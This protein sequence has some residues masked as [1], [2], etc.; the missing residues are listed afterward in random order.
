MTD[1]LLLTSFDI[2]KPHHVSNASDD[3]LLEMLSRNLLNE[4]IHLL[5][6]LPVDFDLAPQRVIDKLNELSPQT[7]ICCGMAERRSR[8]MIELNGKQPGEV[9]RTSVDVKSLIQQLENTEISQDAGKF[10]CN[11]LYHSLL[12]Y[13]QVQ[14]LQTQCLFVHVPIL[15]AS[16]LEPILKDFSK[17]LRII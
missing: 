10:V 8:L 13:V 11:H 2:W 14:N 4:R 5:R 3:L 7:I 15:N 9:I 1:N 6:K 17:L 16:N 12:K